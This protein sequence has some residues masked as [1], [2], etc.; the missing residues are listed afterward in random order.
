MASRHRLVLSMPWSTSAPPYWFEA[1]CVLLGSAG[2]GIDGPRWFLRV[3]WTGGTPL[4]GRMA[5]ALLPQALQDV[6]RQDPL[7]AFRHLYGPALI[8]EQHDDPQG[9][10]ALPQSTQ[11]FRVYRVLGKS[12]SDDIPRVLALS[13]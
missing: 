9:R 3:L 13:E 8:D 6:W 10:E 7:T 11:Q 4:G 12:D 5:R 1:R 2:H